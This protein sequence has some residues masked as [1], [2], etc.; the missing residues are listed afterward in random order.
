MRPRSPICMPLPLAGPR[1]RLSWA[2]TVSSDPGAPSTKTCPRPIQSSSG[3]YPNVSSKRSPEPPPE[4]TRLAASTLT[5][6]SERSA[7]QPAQFGSAFGATKGRM[8][9]PERPRLQRHDVRPLGEARALE[10]HHRFCAP[11][12]ERV[13]VRLHPGRCGQRSVLDR[14]DL[15]IRGGLGHVAAVALSAR[16]LV[17][18]SCGPSSANPSSGRR[19]RGP[20]QRDENQES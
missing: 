9:G 8:R 5:K 19:A 20:E 16:A 10:P 3:L 4:S 12:V 11:A 17:Q 1:T 6:P 14:R 15:P 7:A 13:A 2:L 18:I